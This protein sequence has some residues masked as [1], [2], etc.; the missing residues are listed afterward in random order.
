MSATK[1]LTDQYFDSAMANIKASPTT[2]R[3]LDETK[4]PDGVHTSNL[5]MGDAILLRQCGFEPLGF[6]TGNVVFRLSNPGF[7]RNENFEVA[8]MTQL[9][10]NS[11]EEATEI[12]RAEAHYLEADGIVGMDL[13]IK[14]IDEKTG[15]FEFYATGTAVRHI[16]RNGH[17]R[18]PD[19][20]PFTSNYSGTDFYLTIRAGY[21]PLDM[22]M[23]CSIYHIARRG[24]GSIIAN[25][26][27][28]VR[29]D[30]YTQAYHSARDNAISRMREHAIADNGH[31]VHDMKVEERHLFRDSHYVEFLAF[32]TTVTLQDG[33]IDHAADLKPILTLPVID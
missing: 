17:W 8:D 3:R 24:L 29:M 19:G 25:A 21:R 22:V 16:D 30:N 31:M 32:G 26:G 10:Y 6:V 9:I 12:M 23:G 20:K 5:S 13:D 14:P 2:R 4:G 7:V 28:S 11:R 33:A 1:T 27:R 18:R 15:V